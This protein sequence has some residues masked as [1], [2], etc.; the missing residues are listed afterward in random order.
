MAIPSIIQIRIKQTIEIAVKIRNSKAWPLFRPL[1]WFVRR[2]INVEKLLG[3][4]ESQILKAHRLRLNNLG[5]TERPLHEMQTLVNDNIMQKS[6]SWELAL[7]HANQYSSENALK[8]LDYLRLAS[9]EEND[10]ERL[11]CIAVLTAECLDVLGEQGSGKEIITKALKNRPHPDLY[12]AAANLEQTMPEKIHWINKAFEQ[13]GLLPVSFEPASDL[14][15][16][17]RLS[18]GGDPV[19]TS[20]SMEKL[21]RVSVIVPAFNARKTISTALDSLL[22]QRWKNLEILV[23]DDCSI[24]CTAEVVQ[25]YEKKDSRIRLIKARE[26]QGPYVARNIAL[27]QATGEFVTCH[28]SDDWSHP[29]KIWRQADHL[30]KNPLVVA[31]TSR[32]SRADNGL[33]FFRR[34]SPGQYVRINMSSLMFRRDPVLKE[35]GYWDCVRFGADGEF[36][37]RLKKIFGQDSVRHLDTGPLSFLRQTRASLT[38]NSHFGYHG[39]FMGARKEYLES[40]ELYH[41]KADNLYFGFPQKN[42]LFPVPDPMLPKFRKKQRRH[43]EVVMVSDFGLPGGTTAS[44]IEEI[45]AQIKFGL[46]TGLVQMSR[47]DLDPTRGMNQTIRELID[48]ELVQFIVYG[49]KISCDMLILRHPPVLQERQRFVPDIQAGEIR[50]I[51]NQTPLKHYGQDSKILYDIP[52]CAQNLK[53]YFH[54]SGIWHPIGPLV[55]SALIKHHGED[56]NSISLAEDD[57][58][59]IIDISR[60]KRPARLPGRDKII[61]GRHSR[62]DIFKWPPR[63]EE[64]LSVYPVSDGYEIHVLGGAESPKKILGALPANWKVHEFGAMH[65]KDFLSGVDVFVYYTHP[66]LIESFGR[67]IFEAMAAGVP[68]II[69]PY[70]KQLFGEAAIYAEP[71]DVKHIIHNLMD[72][73]HLYHR[74][75]EKALDYVEKNFGYSKH[76]SRLKPFIE[77]LF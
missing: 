24:D 65:P 18:P 46:R 54:K 28:D 1:Y 51:V 36:L 20:L 21:P 19:N 47:Y 5:F 77:K 43:L 44:N 72:D 11:R 3:G 4:T 73:D 53:H 8:C 50:V 25:E 26:N 57:W 12:L 30:L 2:V 70:Y 75:V 14:P 16:F 62:D 33:K 35:A 58:H 41:A 34:G 23:I 6:A 61:I 39:Y 42:R 76:A 45:S 55:R 71:Y 60:W 29:L 31:N 59:N 63:P 17:D 67:V 27:Q 7:W 37:R 66:N 32:L 38:G 22:T 40:F 69:P 48:G 10:P 15:F 9:R 74:Q 68:V 64:L 49:E 13:S 52:S 56:L